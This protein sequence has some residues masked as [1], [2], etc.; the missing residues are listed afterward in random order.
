MFFVEKFDGENIDGQHPR[1]S[2]LV[3][4]LETIE[5]ENFDGLLAW[6]QIH[7]ML[8]LVKKLCYAV[9]GI[10]LKISTVK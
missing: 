2:V 4:L 7:L 8:S 5:K 9:I 10:G 6:W 1:P 3:I